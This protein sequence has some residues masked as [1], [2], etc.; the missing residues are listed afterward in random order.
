VLK[1]II[2][3]EVRMKRRISR[4]LEPGNMGLKEH[5]SH[6]KC[7]VG[8]RDTTSNTAPAR[9]TLIMPE[10][11]LAHFNA[12]EKFAK[13]RQRQKEI[14]REIEND[15]KDKRHPGEKAITRRD[16]HH[17]QLLTKL[18]WNSGNG[19]CGGT[20]E[21]IWTALAVP[22]DED[23]NWKG[24]S[25]EKW[26]KGAHVMVQMD[27]EGR[28]G[29]LVVP[30]RRMQSG[31]DFETEDMSSRWDSDRLNSKRLTISEIARRSGSIVGSVVHMHKEKSLPGFSRRA[32]ITMQRKHQD[33]NQA[34]AAAEGR[35]RNTNVGKDNASKFAVETASRILGGF[36]ILQYLAVKR[37]VRAFVKRRRE[38]VTMVEEGTW[39]LVCLAQHEDDVSEWGTVTEK[40][41]QQKEVGKKIR[42][43]RRV[44]HVGKVENNQLDPLEAGVHVYANYK[45]KGR[46]YMATIVLKHDDDTFGKPLATASM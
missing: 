2:N 19:E 43:G 4:T 6:S 24:N 26:P 8:R 17:D 28:E 18:G 42:W 12:N 10:F 30:S 41:S 21:E 35:E 45:G 36:T 25:K 13:A 46:F 39:V 23:K 11:T 14:F 20:F 5:V 34:E 3:E 22:C 31:V 33:Q 37:M 7:E 44:S 27:L 38:R 32:S 40:E 9:D 15:L 29:T 1:V 16:R